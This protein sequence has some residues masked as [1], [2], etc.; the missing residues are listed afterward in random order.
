M[1]FENGKSLSMETKHCIVISTGCVHSMQLVLN[2][3]G[4][5]VMVMSTLTT[6]KVCTDSDTAWSGFQTP[7]SL[8]I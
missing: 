2:S 8:N 1:V 3:A 5:M 4:H 7:R 6:I